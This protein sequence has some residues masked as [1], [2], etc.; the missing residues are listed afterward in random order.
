MPGT[1]P[2]LQNAI[3][4]VGA[5][6]LLLSCLY[7]W[8]LRIV[9][10]FIPL[11]IAV[12]GAVL[13]ALSGNLATGLLAAAI[14]FFLAAVCWRRGWLGGADVK[15]LG[16]GTLL[17][18]PASACGFVLATCLSGGVLALVYLLLGRLVAP[19]GPRAASAS[20]LQRIV[21]VERRRLQRRGPLPYAT[22][23]AFGACAAM[24][25]R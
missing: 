25:G 7:D 2:F 8:A 5:A 14:V 15:L 20:L 10:N 4:V 1:A 18:P 23:I 19:P 16:A 12:S 3:T 9:P 13:R 21:R 22:A 17:A 6:L 24:I 11:A